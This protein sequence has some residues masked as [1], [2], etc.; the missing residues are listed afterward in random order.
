MAANFA[1]N[2]DQIVVQS[3]FGRLVN[4]TELMCR[5]NLVFVEDEVAPAQISLAFDSHEHRVE[6]IRFR[7][8]QSLLPT[9][10]I[11]YHVNVAK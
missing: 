7:Q 8:L 11:C 6:P 10:W 5:R 1:A 2:S 9:H 4:E 3:S